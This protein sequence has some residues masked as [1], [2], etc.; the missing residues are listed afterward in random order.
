MVGNEWANMT[1]NKHMYDAEH[2][3]NAKKHL[4]RAD[5]ANSTKQNHAGACLS[6]TGTGEAEWHDSLKTNPHVCDSGITFFGSSLPE[7]DTRNMNDLVNGEPM[8]GGP[9]ADSL[10]APP[11][12]PS[13]RF[14][15][16]AFR[17]VSKWCKAAHGFVERKIERWKLLEDLYHNGGNQFLG[18]Q[19][20]S[21][22]CTESNRPWKRPRFSQGSVA[23][24]HRGLAVL[25]RGQLTR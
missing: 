5:D 1:L 3:D 10:I 16:E 12:I 21:V 17:Y 19:F 15:E 6:P 18:R 25:H 24:G 23:G 20:R 2:P 22:G 9:D 7:Q 14:Q 13:K 11:P 4:P 8:S